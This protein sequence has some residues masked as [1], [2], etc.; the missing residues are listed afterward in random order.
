MDDEAGDA[1]DD[2]EC[3]VEENSQAVLEEM[4]EFISD[5]SDNENEPRDY[6]LQSL[7]TQNPHN[8][9]PKIFQR[10]PINGDIS[11]LP[12]TDSEHE[13]EEEEDEEDSSFI[14]D[15]IIYEDKSPEKVIQ[16][17]EMQ[18]RSK[19]LIQ[20]RNV[21]DSPQIPKKKRRKRV[22]IESP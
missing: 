12:D 7:L 17:K 8:Q 15:E 22:I 1:Y 13:D 19:R 3:F 16:A 21:Q 2:E 11:I 9:L 6:Y 5:T 10:K 18:L 4:A 20:R 14:C